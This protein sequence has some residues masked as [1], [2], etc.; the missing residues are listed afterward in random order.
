M[1]SQEVWDDRTTARAA[2]GALIDERMTIA[3]MPDRL[4]RV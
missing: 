4:Q 3:R 2:V 1:A